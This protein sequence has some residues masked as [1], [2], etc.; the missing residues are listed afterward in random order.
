MSTANAILAIVASSML[1]GVAAFVL[2]VWLADR[3]R[4][5]MPQSTVDLHSRLAA[6]RTENDGLIDENRELRADLAAAIRDAEHAALE[7]DA[8]N[9]DNVR[10][11]KLVMRH[12]GRPTREVA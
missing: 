7:R 4:R 8:I 3:E 1:T 2:T 10:M 6:M 5:A 11:H 9:E 12:V